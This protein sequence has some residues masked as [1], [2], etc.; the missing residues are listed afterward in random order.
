MTAAY[1]SSKFCAGMHKL[2]NQYSSETYRRKNSQ[3]DNHRV[4][5]KM[6]E[7]TQPKQSADSS[8]HTQKFGYLAKTARV[9]SSA[10][11]TD[12]DSGAAALP[13]D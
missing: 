1:H 11:S 7:L 4:P 8:S 5:P 9:V 10:K 13:S 6:I 2:K 12:F 3:Q